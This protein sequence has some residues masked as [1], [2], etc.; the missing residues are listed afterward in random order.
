MSLKR[1]LDQKN[2]W[3]DMM[4][5]PLLVYGKLNRV[6]IKDL[7]ENIECDLSPE[8]LTHDGELS[9]AAVRRQYRLLHAAKV[10][11]EALLG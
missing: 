10:E 11:L 1:Y 4:G 3:I 7:L 5:K 2:I 9:D 8:N 6:Q